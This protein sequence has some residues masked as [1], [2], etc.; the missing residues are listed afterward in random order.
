M[1]NVAILRSVVFDCFILLPRGL[2]RL[3]LPLEERAFKV[4]QANSARGARSDAECSVAKEE[5]VVGKKQR[6]RDGELKS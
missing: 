4:F 3:P 1:Q 6:A 2:F 5:G